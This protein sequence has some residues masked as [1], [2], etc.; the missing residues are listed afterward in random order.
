MSDISSLLV[1]VQQAL[2]AKNIAH[3]QQLIDQLKID[4]PEDPD[5]RYFSCLLL[6]Y[7]ENIAKR[8]PRY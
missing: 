3:A 8:Y 6:R 4:S 7:K 2:A 5:A 1:E